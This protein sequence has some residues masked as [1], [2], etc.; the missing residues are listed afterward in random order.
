MM[1][2]THLA[3]G[4]LTA[5]IALLVLDIAHPLI[6]L[7]LVAFGALLPDVDHEGSTI[8]RRF[9]LTRWVPWFFEHRGFFHSLWPPA[10]LC[11]L[12]AWAGALWLGLYVGVGYLSHLA[13]DALTHMGI[14]PLH[15]FGNW[16]IAGPFMTGGILELGLFALVVI[17]DGALAARVV[18]I[19]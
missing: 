14:R 8:N 3:I 9:P 6:F 10:I 13:S 4:I 16:R 18:G 1:G 7:A 5:L 17:A 19:L 11:I 12:A 15:P 2:R